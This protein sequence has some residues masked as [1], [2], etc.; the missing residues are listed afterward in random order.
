MNRLKRSLRVC[1]ILLCAVLALAVAARYFILISEEGY[2]TARAYRDG[3]PYVTGEKIGGVVETFQ[4]RGGAVQPNAGY[5]FKVVGLDLFGFKRM[6][7][8]AHP[9]GKSVP[10]AKG[11]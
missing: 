1:L 6:I 9:W 8:S 11:A 10:G 5:Y 4:V 7:V 2:V 3:V